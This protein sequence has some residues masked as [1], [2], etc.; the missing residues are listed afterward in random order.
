MD[1][2]ALRLR[3]VHMAERSPTDTNVKAAFIAGVFALVAAVIAGLFTCFGGRQVNNESSYEMRVLVLDPDGRPIEDA[4]VRA[5]HGGAPRRVP[6]GW[7]IDIPRMHQSALVRVFASKDASFLS[8]TAQYQLSNDLHP[9]V[10]VRLVKNA[11]TGIRG[12]VVDELGRGVPAATVAIVGARD[13][14]RSDASGQFSLHTDA[15]DG[16]Q[17]LVRAQKASYV[18]VTQWHPAGRQP[19]TIVLPK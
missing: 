6:G 18:P 19:V 8:G 17:V 3:S 16:E 4:N 2:Q 7:Q 9:V 15:A 10:A 11:T 13:V 5:S 12:V 1:I 14:V